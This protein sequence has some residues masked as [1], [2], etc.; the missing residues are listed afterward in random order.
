MENQIVELTQEKLTEMSSR[1][2]M[3]YLNHTENKRRYDLSDLFK[4]VPL[5][6][7]REY[8]NLTYSLNQILNVLDKKNTKFIR[9]GEDHLR[10]ANTHEINKVILDIKLLTNQFH[11]YYTLLQC[12]VMESNIVDIRDYQ[13][14]FNDQFAFIRVLYRDDTRDIVSD[15]VKELYTYSLIV[16]ESV[17]HLFFVLY[18]DHRNIIDFIQRRE[19]NERNDDGIERIEYY[20]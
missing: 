14:Y 8:C 19:E 12:N 11:D 18:K 20:A 10:I 15:L 6:I 1:V 3:M 5:C 4:V 17:N 16:N 13:K 9:Y 7:N 2:F